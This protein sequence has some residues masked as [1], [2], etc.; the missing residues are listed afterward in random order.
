M[1]NNDKYLLE[2]KI[3]KFI[4]ENSRLLD[5][6]IEKYQYEIDELEAMKYTFNDY[7]K[8]CN[9]KIFKH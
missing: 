9:Y 7:Y 5:N 6:Y 2:S 8:Q 3:Q 4:L 1:E